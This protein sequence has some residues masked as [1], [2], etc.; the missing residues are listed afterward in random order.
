[1]QY[2]LYI[3][4]VYN[5]ICS[6]KYGKVTKL[7]SNMLSRFIFF[8]NKLRAKLTDNNLRSIFNRVET[9]HKQVFQNTSPQ[10]LVCT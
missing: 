10:L 1:M 7:T 2:E 4:T 5:S 8:R 6:K 3:L 9:A